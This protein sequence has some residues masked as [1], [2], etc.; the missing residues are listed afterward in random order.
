MPLVAR[1]SGIGTTPEGASAGWKRILYAMPGTAFAAPA[2]TFASRILPPKVERSTL[3]R[4]SLGGS[5]NSLPAGDFTVVLL[6][7]AGIVRSWPPLARKL[8]GVPEEE[9]LGKPL[10]ALLESVSNRDPA[11]AVR[12]LAD[13]Q[14]VETAASMVVRPRSSAGTGP[15]HL[16]IARASG[17]RIAAVLRDASVESPEPA[18]TLL[19]R[20]AVNA[21]AARI[22]EGIAVTTAGLD[23]TG[24]R[25]LW[26]NEA[27]ARFFGTSLDTAVGRPLLEVIDSEHREELLERIRRELHEGTGVFTRQAIVEREG[28]EP[29]LLEWELAPVQGPDG[30]VVNFVSVQRD[31]TDIVLRGSRFRSGSPDLDYLTGLPTGDHFASRLERAIEWRRRG[32]DYG[33]A[34]LL[35]ETSELRTVERR[36]GS[37]VANTLFEAVAWR[38]R[39]CTR[40][41]DL[42]ARLGFDRIGVLVEQFGADVELAPLLDQIQEGLRNPYVL[43]ERR[44]AMTVSGAALAVTRDR[45]P[46]GDAPQIMATLDRRLGIAVATGGGVLLTVEPEPAGADAR[47]GHRTELEKAIHQQQLRLLYHPIISLDGGH[48]V[49]LEALLRWE[50]PDR[51]L[52]PSRA[53]IADAEA[54][55]IIKPLGRWVLEEV[56]RHVAQWRRELPSESIPPVHVNISTAE[57]WDPELPRRLA[58]MI[59]E[60]RLRPPGLRLEVTE[61]TLARDP[62]EAARVLR[63]LG[64]VGVDVW[65]DRFGA[66]GLPL[67]TVVRLPF[68]HLKVDPELVWEARDGSRHAG[69]L[70]E[71][72]IHLA[73]EMGREAVAGG[74]ETTRERDLLLEVSC[75]LGQGYLFSDPVGPEAIAELLGGSR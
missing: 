37:L 44:L 13:G 34:V 31:M 8:V 59:Q 43:G 41:V 65:L 50:H 69:P 20:A 36:W 55:G 23:S 56:T 68:Q 51:G 58:R 49:G 47:A 28:T 11:D 32:G 9:A 10:E 73:R 2:A 27:F 72:L 52:L 4:P 1:R 35:L 12:C 46:P 24:P 14:S 17:D 21:A 64:A 25:I 18:F 29:I 70:L 5:A 60:G 74:V 48:V 39:R 30:A 62:V 63:R 54:A 26:A 71:S 67:T 40:P 6:D 38:I 75:R 33:F 3:W 42:V 66:G 16:S 19:D 15:L 61:S 22:S 53:F 7:S 57:F 45:D